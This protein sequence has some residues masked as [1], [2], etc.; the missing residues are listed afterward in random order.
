MSDFGYHTKFIAKG[1]Y[2]TFDKIKEEFEELEDAW[3]NR[4]STVLS[5]CELCDL[6][7]AMKEFA[8][9]TLNI[10]MSEVI[11]FSTLTDKVYENRPVK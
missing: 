4:E 7:G 3:K 11:K 6:Y 5:I 10:P 9:K 8:E 1:E 2:G